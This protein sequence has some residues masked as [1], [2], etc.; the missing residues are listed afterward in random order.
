LSPY[1]LDTNILSDLV[2]T[3]QGRIARRVHEVGE[4]LVFTSIIAAGELRYGAER[5]GSPRLT[6][7]VEAVLN[8]MEVL[9]LELPVDRV[10]AALRTRLERTGQVISNNDLLIAAHALALGY[11]VVTDN[12]HEFRRIEELAVENWLRG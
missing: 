8:S 12:E 4:G 7:Q 5:R 6:V 9:A 3:P 2:A 11:T 1:L 10:Y